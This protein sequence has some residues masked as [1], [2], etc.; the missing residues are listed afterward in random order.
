MLGTCGSQTQPVL[1]TEG[2]RPRAQA[3]DPSL[4]AEVEPGRV[5]ASKQG[6]C[7]S[8]PATPPPWWPEFCSQELPLVRFPVP[9]PLAGTLGPKESLSLGVKV[10]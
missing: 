9:V 8:H 10:L 2:A 4:L 5:P 1:S 7:W 6:G 3:G